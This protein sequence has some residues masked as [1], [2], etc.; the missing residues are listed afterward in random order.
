M[1][2]LEKKENARLASLLQN[3]KSQSSQLI[4]YSNSWKQ[5]GKLLYISYSKF[6]F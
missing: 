5:G 1:K 6:K 3:R 4:W 2:I